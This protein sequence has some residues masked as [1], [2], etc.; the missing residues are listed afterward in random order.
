M[1]TVTPSVSG[2]VGPAGPAGPPGVPGA[3]GA[4][5]ANAYATTTTNFVQPAVNADVTVAIDSSAWIGVGQSLFV[6]GG[7]FYIAAAVPDATHVTV[8]NKG[9]SG[10]AAV[11][12]T[13]NAGAKVSPAGLVPTA[14]TDL[15][16]GSFNALNLSTTGS[17]AI[18]STT[19]LSGDVRLS[20]TGSIYGRS[21][22]NDVGLLDWSGGTLNVGGALAT[23]PTIAVV[24]AGQLL[25][26]V[27]G[28]NILSLSGA[29]INANGKAVTGVGSL[30][31]NSSPALTG[32]V[33]FGNA[34][35]MLAFRNAGNTADLA[36]MAS[37]SS[38]G[39][40]YNG[41]YHIF[42]VSGSSGLVVSAAVGIQAANGLP[43]VTVGAGA[44]QTGIGVIRTGSNLTILGARNV[45]NTTDINVLST[46]A[47]D[48]VRFCG[49]VVQASGTASLGFYGTTPIAKPSIA[50]VLSSVTDANAK[51]V[52]TSII[53]A[54]TNLGLTA[55]ATT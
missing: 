52:L 13:I 4:A 39:L 7:G 48:V 20:A 35:T 34:T 50:G 29:S 33:R 38:N 49:G 27:A 40:T 24:D 26:R 23:K 45:A 1:L 12:A 32:D 41:V 54:T 6:V 44:T 18:G 5:G 22:A 36:A 51:A 43:F 10:N 28:A 30:A 2:L 11:G 37:D 55:N 8:T 21:G 17:I 14:T 47:T 25:L 46:T 3:P 19:A 16:G 42:Q 53:A 15:T 31:M 9:L